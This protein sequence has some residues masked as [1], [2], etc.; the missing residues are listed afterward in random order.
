MWIFHFVIFINVLPITA[1][2][3]G[4]CNGPKKKELIYKSFH[5]KLIVGG[6]QKVSGDIEMIKLKLN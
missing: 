5:G 2:A 1:T 3:V 4:L 6:S